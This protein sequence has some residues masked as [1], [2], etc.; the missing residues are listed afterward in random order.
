MHVSP[1]L[2]IS[3]RA[4]KLCESDRGMTNRSYALG[5]E[6][7][8]VAL[9]LYTFPFFLIFYFQHNSLVGKLTF[10]EPKVFIFNCI[11]VPLR[12]LIIVS[13]TFI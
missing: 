5:N 3:S 6:L 4:T 2:Q 1:I 13:V 8:S 7:S 9:K 10:N 12:V 11:C